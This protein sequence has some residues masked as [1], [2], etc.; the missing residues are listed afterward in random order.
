MGACT[1][2]CEGRADVPN[3]GRRLLLA[4]TTGETD[5]GGSGACPPVGAGLWAKPLL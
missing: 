2:T 3:C 4:V 5:V 1:G